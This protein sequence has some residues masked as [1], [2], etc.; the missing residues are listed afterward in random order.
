MYADKF[1]HITSDGSREVL[2]AHVLVGEAYDFGT[3]H[4][5]ELKMPPIKQQSKQNITNIKYDSVSGITNDTRVY[6]IDIPS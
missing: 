6:M 1:A 5:R 2:I 3:S 4:N